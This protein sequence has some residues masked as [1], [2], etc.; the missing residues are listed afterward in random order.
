MKKCCIKI[1]QK[2]HRPL[3]SSLDIEIKL[4]RWGMGSFLYLIPIRKSSCFYILRSRIIDKTYGILLLPTWLHSL[5]QKI[6]FI[7]NN[8]CWI[9]KNGKNCH[10]R[11]KYMRKVTLK[12]HIFGLNK[13]LILKFSQHNPHSN[14]II[15]KRKWFSKIQLKRH[16]I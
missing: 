5:Q 11:G 12:R 6:N 1:C 3:C 15:S 2:L 14:R 10:F 13:V 7:C 8:I 4:W 9:S 16:F